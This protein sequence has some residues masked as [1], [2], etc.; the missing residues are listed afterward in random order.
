MTTPADTPV[1][2]TETPKA[3]SISDEKLSFADYQ[4]LR[5]GG[6]L[7]AS[8]A[9]KSAPA[10]EPS[11]EQKK[12]EESDTSETE[13]KAEMDDAEES[14]AEKADGSDEESTTDKTRKGE[15]GFKKRIRKLTAQK[16]DVQRERDYWRNVATQSK[17]ATEAKKDP[18]DSP[19]PAKG[20][21]TPDDFET[22]TQYV[23]ALT[24]WE[25]DQRDQA[26]KA[27]QEKSKLVFEQNAL[28]AAYAEKVKSF[29][30]QTEDYEDVIDGAE[31]VPMSATMYQVFITSDYGPAL[32]Y[33][34][35][36]NPKEAAR[37]AGLSTVA[38]ARELG[39]IEARLAAKDSAEKKTEPKQTTQAPKPLTPV[40]TSKGTASKSLD[41]PNISFQD[42]VRLRRDQKKRMRG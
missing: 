38:A 11:Q 4:V 42:Y 37:I 28:K 15:G 16:A 29:A 27:E 1:Q 7:P 20:E 35:A 24:K 14:D 22:H 8:E 40:G 26:S 13:S 2:A 34:M 36:K 21:P 39:K 12:S 31:N 9:A 41:D 23:K 6:T 32:A 30:E 25:I 5:R 33:E 19:A 18:I 3:P 17:G 10:K